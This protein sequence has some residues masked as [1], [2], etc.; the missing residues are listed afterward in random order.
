MYRSFIITDIDSTDMETSPIDPSIGE[1]VYLNKLLLITN[2]DYIISSNV[3]GIDDKGDYLTL[4]EFILLNDNRPNYRP[5]AIELQ[6]Y[7]NEVWELIVEDLYVKSDILFLKVI[8]G[9]RGCIAV[10]NEILPGYE[11]QV[12]LEDYPVYKVLFLKFDYS[13]SSWSLI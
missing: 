7:G 13:N 3:K 9:Q 2:N 6:L 12:G 4:E 8:S 5:V 10:N 11:H 1:S